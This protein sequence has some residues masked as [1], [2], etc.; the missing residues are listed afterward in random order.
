MQGS[1]S[2]LGHH[3]SPAIDGTALLKEIPADWMEPTLTIARRAAAAGHRVWIVG[4][5]VRDLV[6]GDPI[7]DID[8][9]SA[10]L[11]DQIEALFDRTVPVGKAF[12]IVVVVEGGKEVELATFR[13]ERGYSDQRRPDEIEFATEPAIDARRRDFTCN[14][15]YLDPLTGEIVDPTGGLAD[16]RCGELRAVGDAA[17]RFRE[18]GLRLLRAGRFIARLGLRPASG[19]VEAMRAEG[20]SISGVS[21][22]RV[23]DELSKILKTGD[24]AHAIEILAGAGILGR[25][26]PGWNDQWRKARVDALGRAFPNQGID[27]PSAVALGLAILLEPLGIPDETEA[28]G[29]LGDGLD[30][31]RVSRDRRS[32]ALRLL[33][34]RGK[35]RSLHDEVSHLPDDAIAVGQRVALFRDK[36][37]PAAWLFATSTDQAPR[38]GGAAYAKLRLDLAK[39]SA[40]APMTPPELTAADAM[41]A[42][43]ERGPE[44][45]E[46]LRRAR[47][48]A[49][50]GAFTTREGA[51]EWLA[52]Q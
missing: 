12:G 24:P 10:A 18:D 43:V 2:P 50:G 40:D 1:E 16:L 45:G 41:E 46:I 42:G 7:K 48:A 47:F 51:L 19:L 31:L 28:R 6:L 38:D 11:P 49:L 20:T 35:I 3:P 8:L 26:V 22:E 23:H 4:G 52:A 25:C 37:F 39:N 33:E 13:K 34:L 29:L 14:A 30:A 15:L 9:V 5:A 44:L 36:D 27:E 32:S 17:A 21:P